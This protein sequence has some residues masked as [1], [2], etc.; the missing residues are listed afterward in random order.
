MNSNSSSMGH[1]VY[2]GDRRQSPAVLW[3]LSEVL[4]RLS[5]GRSTWLVGVRRGIYPA[6]V[7]L[8]PRRVAWRPDDIQALIERLGSASNGV[9]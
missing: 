1:A 4:D 6:P 9:S 5:L 3:S 2:D 8:S 7:R